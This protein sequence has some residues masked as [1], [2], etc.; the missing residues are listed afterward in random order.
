MADDPDK[1]KVMSRADKKAILLN[2][3]EIL[4]EKQILRREMVTNFES[5]K[6]KV[7]MMSPNEIFALFDDDDS[8]VISFE[9][10][11]KMLPFVSILISDAKAFRYF[12]ICDTDGSGEIDYDEFRVA[13]Y[14][15]DPVSNFNFLLYLSPRVFLTL[16]IRFSFPIR[17]VET[18]L[19]SSRASS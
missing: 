1:S 3:A 9:E 10:F 5:V 17:R 19:D 12:R 4:T 15:C 6:E 13:L 2:D 7:K 11:R 14:M 8:G 18:Q 16:I